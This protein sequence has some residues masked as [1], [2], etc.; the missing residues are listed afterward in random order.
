MKS[1]QLVLRLGFS[2][3]RVVTCQHHLKRELGN[4]FGTIARGQEL[5]VTSRA[6]YP[7]AFFIFKVIFSDHKFGE[8]TDQISPPN[9]LSSLLAVRDIMGRTNI[10]KINMS[11]P[12]LFIL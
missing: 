4:H 7:L 3:H 5:K 8:G 9:L 1:G 6:I 11:K 2:K 12:I 10:V